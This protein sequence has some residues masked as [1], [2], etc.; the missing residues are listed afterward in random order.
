MFPEPSVDLGVAKQSLIDANPMGWA[1]ETTDSHITI[2]HL[3]K[4]NTE[5][6]VDAVI[7]AVQSTCDSISGDRIVTVE[8]VLRLRN[9]LC[10]AVAP[11]RVVYVREYLLASFRDRG[12]RADTRFAGIPHMT[13]GKLRNAYTPLSPAIPSFPLSFRGLTIACGDARVACPFSTR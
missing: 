8:G 11:E 6:T 12:V 2:S 9:H 5:R 1:E 3:G 10:I 13:V 7:S 4:S